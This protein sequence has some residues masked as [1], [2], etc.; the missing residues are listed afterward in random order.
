MSARDDGRAAAQRLLR[1]D[2]LSKES[3]DMI[4]DAVMDAFSIPYRAEVE[5]ELIRKMRGQL[6]A[7]LKMPGFGAVVVVG[8]KW[9]PMGTTHILDAWDPDR[10]GTMRP[11][12][13]ALEELRGWP[14]P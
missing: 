2:P 10:D 13:E 9:E 1:T 6:A 11:A 5:R 8:G 4:A 12:A 3:V 14:A 7:G